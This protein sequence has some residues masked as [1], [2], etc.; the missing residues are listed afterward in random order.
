M[1]PIGGYYGWDDDKRFFK[2]VRN[3]AYL[4]DIQ[5]LSPEDIEVNL[6]LQDWWSEEIID[7]DIPGVS[8]TVDKTEVPVIPYGVTDPAPAFEV[9]PDDPAFLDISLVDKDYKSVDQSNGFV[10]W[11]KLPKAGSSLTKAPSDNRIRINVTNM[12]LRM[13]F[14]T[15]KN[16][17]PG[18]ILQGDVRKV[19]TLYPY[20][21]P[22]ICSYG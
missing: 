14:T 21:N 5:V 16:G 8:F 3:T 7:G 9:V 13:F 2:L 11:Y 17:N 12:G 15:V 19:N 1:I 20:H 6:H 22:Q 10:L 18:W 4:L